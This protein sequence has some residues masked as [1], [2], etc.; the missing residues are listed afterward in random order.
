MKLE[1][2]RNHQEWLTPHTF[3]WYAQIAALSGAYAYSWKSTIAEPNAETRFEQEVREMIRDRI[4]LDVGCGHGEFTVQWSPIVK[5]ITGLDVTSGFI[6][7][8]EFDCAYNRRGP[9]SCYPHMARVL[10]PGGRLLALHPG[11]RLSRELPRLFPGFFEPAPDGTPI[12]DRL[13][14]R[15]EQGGLKQ[16]EIETVTSV[17]YL[18]DPMDVIRI[19]CFGQSPVLIGKVIDES[20]PAIEE[21]FRRHATAQ[22]LPATY[23]HYLVRAV[24]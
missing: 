20:L 4:V 5:R 17:Q 23:E 21:I 3:A 8:G 9:T 24:S 7:D 16:V 11:D 19:R 22:G 13:A 1:D 10:K 15:L 14:Q 2:P 6:P 12:L 18:H